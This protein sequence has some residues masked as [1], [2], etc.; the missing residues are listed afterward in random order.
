MDEYNTVVHLRQSP[1]ETE[2]PLKLDVDESVIRD[3]CFIFE[4]SDGQSFNIPVA[5][6]LLIEYHPDGYIETE[7]DE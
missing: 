6:V 2:N 4:C 1:D 3:G 5:N 7:E